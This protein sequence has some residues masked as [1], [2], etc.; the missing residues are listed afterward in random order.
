MRTEDDLLDRFYPLSGTGH[1][2]SLELVISLVSGNH[3]ASLFIALV[4]GFED[5]GRDCILEVEA[6]AWEVEFRRIRV[7]SQNITTED[8]PISVVFGP[9]ALGKVASLANIVLGRRS[10]MQ[11][12]VMREHRISHLFLW[13][14]RIEA[15][16]FLG[17]VHVALQ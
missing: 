10:V 11:M 1:A 13:Y 2:I 15:D 3:E 16:V 5:V 17:D 12:G 4:L 14:V 9:A 7:V 8:E 6:V